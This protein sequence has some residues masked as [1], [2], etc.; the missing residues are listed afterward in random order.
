MDF[1]CWNG[2]LNNVYRCEKQCEV[3]EVKYSIAENEQ[4]GQD[5]KKCSEIAK[6]T[7]ETIQKACDEL[8]R[9]LIRK[10]H[11]YGNSVE[12]QF[13]EYG[14]T[15]LHLRLEDKLRRLKQLSKHEAKVK[16][17]KAETWIDAAGYS[18]LAYIIHSDRKE[19]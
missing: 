14:D 11:D 1:R 16:E 8:A 17:K 13:W 2:E 9:T 7:P 12:E 15:S 5:L 10:N 19:G 6:V 18:V 4:K 3:C